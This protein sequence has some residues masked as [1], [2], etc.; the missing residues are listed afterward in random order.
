[1]IPAEGSFNK[2]YVTASQH[3][4]SNWFSNKMTHVFHEMIEAYSCVYWPSFIIIFIVASLPMLINGFKEK[5]IFIHQGYNLLINFIIAGMLMPVRN[6]PYWCADDN[7]L[8]AMFIAFGIGYSLLHFRKKVKT[9]IEFIFFI[10]FTLFY[11]SIIGVIANR[12]L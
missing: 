6:P 5:S 10:L 11:T 7:L 9:R 1:M 3:I 2:D 4:I 12:Y 8:E